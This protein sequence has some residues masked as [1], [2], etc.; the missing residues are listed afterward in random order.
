MPHALTDR[1][2]LD[3][4]LIQ[5]PMAGGPTTPALVAAV[6]NAGALGAIGAGYLS[7]RSLAIRS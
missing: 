7:P 5:A 6:S 3:Y 2:D 1:L 4:A